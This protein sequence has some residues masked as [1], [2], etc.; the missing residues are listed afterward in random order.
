MKKLFIF[1]F[2]L[3]LASCTTVPRETPRTHIDGCRLIEEGLASWYG[4]EMA[5]G[6]RN[7]KYYFNPTAS[8]EEFIPEG[9]SAAHPTLPFGTV[10]KVVL[11]REGADPNGIMVRIN[12]RG[13]FV[14]GRIIDLSRGASR[15]LGMPDT[16]KVRVYTCN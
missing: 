11:D 3:L 6:K 14:K 16:Q 4:N 7:G 9:I 15:L 5:K 8:G 1:G 10:V 2:V 12:D 13:P